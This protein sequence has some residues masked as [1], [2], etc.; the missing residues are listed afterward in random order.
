MATVEVHD[1]GYIAALLHRE[2][3]VCWGVTEQSMKYVRKHAKKLTPI[4]M[5]ELLVDEGGD[6]W[7]RF[8]SKLGAAV[9]VS[10][11]CWGYAGEGP[12]GLVTMLKE[13]GFKGVTMDVVAGLDRTQQYVIKKVYEEL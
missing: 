9:E 10:G 3:P 13:L 7:V 12:G 5:V 4:V 1:K 6:N 11:F 2:S 8:V